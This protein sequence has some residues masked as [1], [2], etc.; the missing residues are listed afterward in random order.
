MGRLRRPQGLRCQTRQRYRATTTSRY[1]LPVA[2]NDLDRPFRVMT[3]DR[4]YAG[5]LTSVPTAEGGLYLSVFL[6][7]FSRPV[8]GWAMSARLTVELAFKALQMAAWR[9][10]PGRGVLVHS[11]RAASMPPVNSKHYSGTLASGAA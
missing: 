8:V 10:R 4:V 11:D 5:D 9:R 7:L 3:P 1:H 6:D 2:P